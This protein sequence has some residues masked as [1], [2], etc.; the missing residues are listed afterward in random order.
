MATL[1]QAYLKTNLNVTVNINKSEWGTFSESA[2][3]G[4]ADMYGMSWTWYPDPY[5]FLNKLFSSKE[6]GALGNGQGFSNAEVDQL[7]DD[8]LKATDQNERAEMYKKSTEDRDRRTAGYLLSNENVIHGLNPESTGFC[9]EGR[10]PD[11]LCDT[12][13]KCLESTVIS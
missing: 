11:V 12:V 13:D 1:V 8:A 4:N 7:L 9:T 6:I 3:S 10:Q 5:F 2:A